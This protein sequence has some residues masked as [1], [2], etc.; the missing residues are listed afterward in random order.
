VPRVRTAIVAFGIVV[1]GCAA[2]VGSNPVGPGSPPATTAASPSATRT[3]NPNEAARA[4]AGATPTSSVA[5]PSPAPSTS[6]TPIPTARVRTEMEARLPAFMAGGGSQPIDVEE[7]TAASSDA[8]ALFRALLDRSGH[9]ASDLEGAFAGCC[10]GISVTDLRIRG[11]DP[12][13]LAGMFAAAYASTSPGATVT[14]RTVGGTTVRRLRWSG[15]AARD[16]H[17]VVLDQLVYVFAGPIDRQTEV[18]AAI[19][20][21]RRPRLDLLLPATIAG[22]AVQRFTLPGS[23]IPTGGDM[24][25]FVCPGELQGLASELGVKVGQI[26]VAFAASSELPG[27]AI[28]AFRVPGAS[29][30]RLASARIASTGTAFGRED[31]TIGGKKVTLAANDPYPESSRN[32]YVYAKDDVVY[33]I[34]PVVFDG[35]P[36]DAV[37]ESIR[38]LP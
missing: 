4:S 9:P 11:V 26:D 8:A 38:A 28:V 24:C 12:T 19:G 17:V 13:D 22:K 36:T 37:V 30:A 15:D 27:A 34:R 25:S 16:V 20:F 33:S 1:T 31:R 5:T 32:E 23:A 2:P 7:L 29:A 18:D 21:M 3:L 6:P 35:P 14:T 10:S